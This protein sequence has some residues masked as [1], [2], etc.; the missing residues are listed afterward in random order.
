[1]SELWQIG[2]EGW[3][4][5]DK[6]RLSRLAEQQAGRVSRRQL[7]RLGVARATV[8]RWVEAGYLH[9]RLPGVYAV[10]YVAPGIEGELAEALLYVGPGAML[11]HHTGV[12]WRG[13][14]DRRPFMIDISTPRRC[15]S[16]DRVRVHCRRPPDREWHRGFPTTPITTTLL[17]Y[18]VVAPLDQLRYVL[19]EAEYHNLLDIEAVATELGRGRRGSAKLRRALKRHQPR[20]A[21][22]R[23][24]LER[25][26]LELCEAARIPLPEVNVKIAGMTVDAVWKEAGVVVE[27]DGTRGHR[28]KAQIERDRGRE[29]QLRA[30]GLPVVN[31]YTEEQVV[32]DAEAVARDLALAL[33]RSR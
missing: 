24:R 9:H 25:R 31:R 14:T 10:G 6:V 8:S 5:N 23:S 18:A 29:L 28:T 26:F 13:L 17:D 22:T 2:S 3:S 1:V 12:W 27:L 20:L 11:S 19:A 16:L 15:R 30:A 4:G 32:F 33:T 21:R 7:E